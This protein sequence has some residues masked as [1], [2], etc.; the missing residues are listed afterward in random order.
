MS[1]NVLKRCKEALAAFDRAEAAI[2]NLA[3]A[4]LGRG[5]SFCELNRYQDALIAYEKALALDPDLAEAWFGCGNIFVQL[6]EH[7]KALA[8]FERALLLKPDL[9]F[10]KGDWIRAKLQI[11]RLGKSGCGNFAT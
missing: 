9:K 8:T 7:D 1:L 6:K 5:N 11:K 3:E 10:A 4:W 2:P